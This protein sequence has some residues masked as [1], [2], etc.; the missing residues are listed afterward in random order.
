[1]TDE[2]AYHAQLVKRFSDNTA[3]PDEIEVFFHLLEKGMLDQFLLKDMEAAEP[4]ILTPVIRRRRW[5]P[6]AVAAAVLVLI[7]TGTW[8]LLQNR[9]QPPSIAA[10][11]P[12]S[13][14][15]TLTLEDGSVISLDSS[16]REVIR[17]GIRREG[18]TLFYEG[19]GA[20]ASFNKLSTP[21]G[22]QFQLK[23]PDGSRVWLNA[24]SSISYPTKFTEGQRIVEITGEVYFEITADASKP[25]SVRINGQ[26]HIDVLGTKFNVNAYTDES[27]ISTT[28][29]E[30]S[31][32]TVWLNQRLVLK[33]GQRAL[34]KDGIKLAQHAD[35]SRFIAWK[36][37]IFNFQDAGLR[38]VMRQLARWY[39]ITVAYE[40][41]VPDIVFEGKMSRDNN[42]SE[43]LRILEQSGVHF[44]M[45]GE[46]RL[47]VMP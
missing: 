23:L 15:A 43:L 22:G 44:R 4:V 17:E 42:L 12:G 30:G 8:L 40:G 41:D 35:I 27:V 32:R 31:I 19:K 37:G 7:M 18:A 25:F 6:A 13:N 24:A 2:Q 28:L 36:D 47:I 5:W 10:I 20:T 29:V 9:V 16:G 11:P 21:R 26:T 46:K 1:M 38:E 33:P 34:V 14:K 39:D 3:T 45:E